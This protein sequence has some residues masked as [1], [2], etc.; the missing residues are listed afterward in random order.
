MMTDFAQ[1]TDRSQNLFP[2]N[3]S[4]IIILQ[5]QA[6]NIYHSFKACFPSLS[7]DLSINSCAIE[8][9]LGYI[10]FEPRAQLANFSLCCGEDLHWSRA[11]R[12]LFG[13]V[14]NGGYL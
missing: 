8:L 9:I 6:R 12:V 2:Y 14:M 11:W 10:F 1:V 4:H 7:C 5:P 3:F 13:S